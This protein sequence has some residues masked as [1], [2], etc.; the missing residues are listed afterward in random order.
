MLLLICGYMGFACTLYMTGVVWF[1]QV[2]HYPLLD[3]G[4]PAAFTA[5]A[6]EYQR[7]T[8][9]VVIPGLTGEIFGA[10]GLVW[11]WPSP[12]SVAGLAALAAI[13]AST[14]FR[15]I[16]AHLALKRVYDQQVHR[17]LVRRNLPRALL[18]TLRS[19]IMIWTILTLP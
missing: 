19:A 14:G 18:W 9:W 16:P 13:W 8:L 3:R 10:A 6:R 12:Q 17:A 11:L 5:F 15:V 4:S 7:R 2:V 1:A